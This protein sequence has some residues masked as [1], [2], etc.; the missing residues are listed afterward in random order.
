M[1]RNE[2]EYEVP[3]EDAKSLVELF[4]DKIIYNRF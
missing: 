4:N 2:F 1:T 3:L